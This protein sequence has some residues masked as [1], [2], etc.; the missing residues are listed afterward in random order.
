MIG[1]SHLPFETYMLHKYISYC[2]DQIEI[3]QNIKK[4]ARIPFPRTTK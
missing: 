4:Q 3:K 2:P 1:P